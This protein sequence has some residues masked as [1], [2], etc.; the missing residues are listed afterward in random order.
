MHQFGKFKPFITR[1]SQQIKTAVSRNGMSSE[2]LVTLYHHFQ[3]QLVPFDE[4]DIR[5]AAGCCY[6]C[7]LRVNA[8]VAEVVVI[9]S[10][11]GKNGLRDTY[12]QRLEGASGKV[13]ERAG[14]EDTWWWE[15]SV[16]CLFLDETTQRCLIYE[17]RPFFC[18][19]YHSLDENRCREGY[20]AKTS[21]AIPCYPDLKRSREMFS[22][23]FSNALTE[24]GLH[25]PLVELSSSAALFLRCPEKVEQWLRGQDVFDGFS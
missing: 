25:A 7:H 9:V 4:S 5:C 12:C 24:L 18:R 17:V 11:L 13:E 21:C 20:L 2:A 10:M 3:S 15:Y 22:L 6:C 8:S 19:G 23:S 1:Y 14:K 16:P